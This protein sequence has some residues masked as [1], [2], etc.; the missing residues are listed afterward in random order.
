MSDYDK[1]LIH[2]RL[3][4]ATE[5]LGEATLLLGADYANSAA[6]RTYYACFYAVMALLA[7]QNFSSK[8]HKGTQILFGKHFVE[9][10]IV[11]LLAGKQFARLFRFRQ[12]GDYGD[13]LEV[14]AATAGELLAEARVFVRDISALALEA[15]A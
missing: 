3:R 13:F 1:E 11:P 8:T 4:R 15:I 12:E 14:D 2:Y 9:T 6:S 5:A 7:T 10:G